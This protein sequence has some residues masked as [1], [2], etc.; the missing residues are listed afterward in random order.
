ML[1]VSTR[2]PPTSNGGLAWWVKCTLDG[3]ALGNAPMWQG[4]QLPP[5]YGGRVRF[6]YEPNHGSGN[7]E[8]A[9][10]PD[11]F[12]RGW[13]DCDDLVNARLTEIYGASLPASFYRLSTQEQSV[14]LNR[15]RLRIARGK[16]PSTLCKWQ[17]SALHVLIRLPDGGEEDPSIKLG[18]PHQ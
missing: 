6:A 18:A 4:W 3:F 15:L 16:L 11:V 13:G 10:P 5:L 1:R 7:E 9:Q 2:I 17:D 14:S 12:A 8:F